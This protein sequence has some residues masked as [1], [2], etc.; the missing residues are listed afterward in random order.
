MTLFGG[1][2]PFK[3]KFYY[4]LY[5]FTQQKCKNVLFLLGPRKCG[6]TVALLQ[7][8]ETLG[9]CAKYVN[10]KASAD[11][12]TAREIKSTIEANKDIIFLVDEITYLD[13][14][15][16]VIADWAATF[17]EVPNCNTKLIITGNQMVA[18]SAWACRSFSVLAEYKR[19]TFIN[20][21]E[22]CEYKDLS[23]SQDSFKD[24]ILNA[25]EFT[26]IVSIQDYIESCLDETIISN[27]KSLN[28]IFNNDCEGLTTKILLA[29]MCTVMFTLH[30]H[31][32]L[33]MY[34]K[35]SRLED[36]AR[37]WFGF[38]GLDE[39]VLNKM[40][41]NYDFLK[42]LNF[43]TFR[44][45][46][47]FLLQA[48]LVS[49]TYFSENRQDQIDVESDLLQKESSFFHSVEDFFL[50]CNVC[51][52]YPLFYACVL[53]QIVGDFELSD[54]LLGS[55]VEC[56]TRGLLGRFSIEYRSK[57]AEI[58]YVD[59][60]GRMAIEINISNKKVS[61][62]SLSTLD[63][64]WEKILLTKDIKDYT[65]GVLRVPYYDFIAKLC[66]K[67]KH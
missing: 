29:V 51:I 8:K 55:I 36:D 10:F 12:N 67:E 11:V 25:R 26:K 30:N 38:T 34:K 5:K 3:R 2:Y 22:W 59:Y 45:S 41:A 15:D 18:I 35:T 60:F 48:D 23:V 63:N 4:T 61:G 57:D 17:E 24:F 58:D 40:L 1:S 65:N 7:L 14:A 6:K 19:I 39:T 62:T 43:Q 54:S 49:I 16:R 44:K 28:V 9:T 66:G 52:K 13:C 27:N 21:A 50:N 37:Y 31:V 42:G 47:L 33:S 53:R 56:Y 46:I 20:Y 64:T 32:T